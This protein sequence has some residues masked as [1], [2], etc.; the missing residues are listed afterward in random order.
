MNT[1]FHEHIC[2]TV[3]CYIDDI[4]V[5]SRDKGN[6]LADL[7]KV[8]DIVRAHQLKMNPIKSLLGVASGK[9]L[10]FVVTSKGIHLDPEKIRAIL[11]CNLQE[12]LKNS[13]DCRDV[14]LTSEHLYQI[15]KD[16]ANPSPG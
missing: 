10:G 12:V 9:F 2:R 15:Y 13:G 1:I 4:A 16:V 3:I 7:K 14:W 8:F 6:H 5:K 11:G